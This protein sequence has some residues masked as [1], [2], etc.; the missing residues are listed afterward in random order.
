MPRPFAFLSILLAALAAGCSAPESREVDAQSSTESALDTLTPAQRA[1][2]RIIYSYPGLTPPAALFDRIRA[3]EAAGVHFWSD[4]VSN[5]SQIR[6]VIARL[7]RAQEESPIHAPLL[8]ITDQEGGTVRGLPGEPVISAKQIGQSPDAVALAWQAG[9]DA[10]R[11]LH[12]VGMNVNLAPVL[13]VFR[14]PGNFID[15]AERSYSQDPH[16]VGRLGASFIG[17]EQRFGVA[18]G[19]KHFPGLGS[20]T[21][22]QNTDLAPV[23]LDVPRADLRR[24]DE[25]PYTAAIAAGAKLV[26]LSWATYPSLDA[27]RPAGL[28]SV[29]VQQE[30]RKRLGFKGVT[31]SETLI[32]GALQPFGSVGQRSVLAADA[33]LDLILC[34]FGD[35]SQGDEAK[36]ALAGAL[37]SGQLDKAAFN[38]SVRR[39]VALRNGLK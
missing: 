8:F 10:G 27:Q 30:L 37:Q 23:T 36:S 11:N 25:G 20:A 29:V 19:V 38:A 28:S 24:V 5:P 21:A 14:E 12:D 39:I 32:A 7:V 1:G 26:M 35:V 13:D 4:N 2:Q 3:G 18:A 17:A 22:S 6:D 16:V 34:S 9:S 33:G 31:I 15:G